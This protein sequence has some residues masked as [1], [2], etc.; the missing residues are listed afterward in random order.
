MQPWPRSICSEVPFTEME[1]QQARNQIGTN[2]YELGNLFL[3]TLQNQ[4][5]AAY[6]F[7]KVVED[8]SAHPLVPRALYSLY[9]LNS[10][11][12]NTTE[13]LKWSTRLSEVVSQLPVHKP[14][15]AAIAE[16]KR[17]PQIQQRKIPL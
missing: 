1:K 12:G 10:S 9:E 6:Y 8:H 13:A 14:A 11:Q 2:K 4:D 16:R 5:S 15:A 17:M 7:R 3:L